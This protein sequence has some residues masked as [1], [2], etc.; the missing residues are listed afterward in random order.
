M[1][2]REELSR[3]IIKVTEAV[4][5]LGYE[6]T[7]VYLSEGGGKGAGGSRRLTVSITREG[8]FSG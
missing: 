7:G 5:P 2:E 1:E 8:G 6:V 4:R 3:E